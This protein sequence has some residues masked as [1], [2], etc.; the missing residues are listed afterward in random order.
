MPRA[1]GAYQ[2]AASVRPHAPAAR[3]ARGRL[4]TLSGSEGSGWNEIRRVFGPDGTV[5][6]AEVDPWVVYPHSQ[7]WMFAERPLPLRAMVRT[8]LSQAGIPA[9]SHASIV[10]HKLTV[11]LKGAKG[12]VQARPG[13]FSAPRPQG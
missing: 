5:A 12:R 3:I 10:W 1:L 9:V 6:R 2:A 4:L 11:R 7:Y 8:S 13:Y